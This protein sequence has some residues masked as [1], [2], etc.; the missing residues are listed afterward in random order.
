MTDSDS[1]S[2]RVIKTSTLDYLDYA[3]LISNSKAS[4]PIFEMK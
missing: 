2:N 4:V 3:I 1:N